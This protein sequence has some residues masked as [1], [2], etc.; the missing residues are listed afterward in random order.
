MPWVAAKPVASPISLPRIWD[1]PADE[2]DRWAALGR[3]AHG[4]ARGS[5]AVAM[6]EAVEAARHQGIVDLWAPIR[7]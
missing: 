3:D 1:F 6:M 4:P 5:Q 7:R 2:I